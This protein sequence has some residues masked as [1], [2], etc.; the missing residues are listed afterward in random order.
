[1]QG[2][3]YLDPDQGQRLGDRADHVGSGV[4]PDDHHHRGQRLALLVDDLCSVG[5]HLGGLLPRGREINPQD[6]P[7]PPPGE[8][9][10]HQ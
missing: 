5:G 3:H 7:D 9:D 4:L 10:D 1:V 6:H 2:L 8:G